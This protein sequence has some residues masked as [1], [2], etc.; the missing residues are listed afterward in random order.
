MVIPVVFEDDDLVVIDKPAGIVVN[1]AQSVKGE[2]VQDWAEK[3]YQISIRQLAD[4]YQKEET[5]E[6][7]SEFFQRS[8]IVHRLDKDT[9]GLLIIAK[10]PQAFLLL[11]SQFKERT[12]VKNYL[13][14]VHGAISPEKGTI[15][16]TV[17]RLPWNREKFGIIVGGRP[18]RTDYC[19]K[20]IYS[21]K[22]EKLSL[23]EVIPHT[24][25][26]HQIRIHLKYLGHS[27][28]SDSLY[29][30][31]KTCRKDLGFCPRLFLHASH[32]SFNQPVSGARLNFESSLPDDLEGV[33]EKLNILS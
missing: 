6:E 20:K 17:G 16:A 28:V 21:Y 27:I 2:T 19:V 23:L 29:A 5:P 3:K 22:N 10:N 9:S 18:S 15:A 31:R 25:R 11:Q 24:G 30:G 33:L 1:K 26:T 4:K 14:L 12:V 32:I 7:E 13:A 8:G